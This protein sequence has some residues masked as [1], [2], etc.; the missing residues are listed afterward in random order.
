[1][2]DNYKQIPCDENGWVKAE[3][4]KPYPFDLIYLKRD[5]KVK[6]GWWT[7]LNYY[8]PRNPK[9]DNIQLWKKQNKGLVWNK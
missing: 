4:Y 6:I 5:K 3:K 2:N 1:M 8:C 9:F 7:G